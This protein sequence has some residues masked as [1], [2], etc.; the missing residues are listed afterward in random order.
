[1]E[2]NSILNHI[3]SFNKKNIDLTYKV[4]NNNKQNKEIENLIKN[5]EHTISKSKDIE[6]ARDEIR[7]LRNERLEL[8]NLNEKMVMNMI[9]MT[10]QLNIIQ[11][12]IQTS[13]EQNI[14]KL[15][16]LIQRIEKLYN[17]I[18][19]KS[20]I[21][22]IKSIGEVFNPDEHEYI[23]QREALSGEIDNQVVEVIKKGYR[24]GTKVLVPVQVKIA[25]K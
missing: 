10:N 20:G 14:T 21:Y 9:E 13:N 23:D 3:K 25:K 4:E 17:K 22:E 7:I 12:F 5:L 16:V 19:N 11:S 1:M 15:P 8:K 24:Y 2:D 6:D 18:L